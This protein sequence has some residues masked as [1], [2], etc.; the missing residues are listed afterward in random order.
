MISVR[1]VSE[2]PLVL[3]AFILIRHVPFLLI[4]LNNVVYRQWAVGDV[5]QIFSE[6]LLPVSINPDAPVELAW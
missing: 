6:L 2:M 1:D 5:I 4:F 3:L